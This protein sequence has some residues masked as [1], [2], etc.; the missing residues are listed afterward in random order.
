MQDNKTSYFNHRMLI[1]KKKLFYVLIW[2]TKPKQIF[3]F[4]GILAPGPILL[5]YWEYC[6]NAN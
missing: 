2:Q 6:L 1:F 5:L 4:F 3:E